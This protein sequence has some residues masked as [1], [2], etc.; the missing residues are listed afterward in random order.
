ME[1][2]FVSSTFRDMQ[3]ER[4]LLHTDIIPE[5]NARA[6]KYGEYFE[7]IDLRWG[8]NTS[9]METIDGAKKVMDVCFDEIDKSSPYMIIFLGNR[10]GWI[11]PIESVENA[12]KNRN[13]KIELI[14]KSITALEIEY[15]LA[16]KNFDRDKCIVC[17]RE[18]DILNEID[19]TN[20]KK[21][22]E[23]NNQDKKNLIKLKEMIISKFGKDIIFYNGSW[24]AAN[25]KISGLQELAA[26]IV[27][28]IESMFIS[29]WEK[30]KNICWQDKEKK[31]VNSFVEHRNQAFF[32]RDKLIENIYIN[33]NKDNKHI[34]AL[35]GQEGIGKTSCLCKI[36]QL[37]ENSGG[38]VFYFFSAKGYRSNTIIDCIK[39][40]IYFMEHIMMIDNHYIGD[41]INALIMKL[42]EYIEDYEKTGKQNIFI[43]IGGLDLLENSKMLQTLA[44]IPDKKLSLIKFILSF[45]ENHNISKVL[46]NSDYLYLETIHKLD[47]Y[48]IDC[49]LKGFLEKNK[50]ELDLKIINV[51]KSKLAKNSNFSPLYIQLIIQRLLM[52]DG[53]DLNNL[54]NSEM[55]NQKIIEI[56]KSCGENIEDLSFQIINIAIMRSNKKFI[57]EVISFLIVSRNGLKSYDL[58]KL[59]SKEDIEWNGLDFSKFLKYMDSFFILRQ[60]GEYDFIHRSVRISLLN[61]FDQRKKYEKKIF[62]WIKELPIKDD[63]RIREGVYFAYINRDF[64]FI[65]EQ[66]KISNKDSEIAILIANEIKKICYLDGVNWLVDII[67]NEV[68]IDT[69]VLIFDFILEYLIKILYNGNNDFD[70]K[71]RIL[72]KLEIKLE[73]FFKLY[74]YTEI[75]RC[76]NVVNSELGKCFLSH[77]NY[78]EAESYFKKAYEIC[79]YLFLNDSGLIDE[80]GYSVACSRLGD[81]YRKTKQFENALIYYKKDVEISEKLFISGIEENKNEYMFLLAVAYEK[82]GESY[83]GLDDNSNGIFYYNKA[84]NL[85]KILLKNEDNKGLMQMI[86]AIQNLGDAKIKVNKFEEAI[87]LFS[88]NIK[89]C[90]KNY[91]KTMELNDLQE[92]VVAYLKLTKGLILNNQYIKAD[93]NIKIAI[94]YLNDLYNGISSERTLILMSEGYKLEAV[95][96]IYKEEYNYA[97]EIYEK[98]NELLMELNSKYPKVQYLEM[99]AINWMQMGNVFKMQGNNFLAKGVYEIALERFELLSQLGINISSIEQKLKEEIKSL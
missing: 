97:V 88:V 61:K 32:G 57:K 36:G 87:E 35:K 14:E 99:T 68:K 26:Y 98:L 8:I 86:T 71:I 6:K 55:I 95:I 39:Q 91:N 62:E 54:V 45:E 96:A 22:L 64:K 89:N 30:E 52:I 75:L 66:M 77:Y 19:E 78:N 18:Q 56:I 37:I 24:D 9:D 28:R 70:I 76:L 33:I 93:K 80:I 60:N 4:D 13:C 58:E 82:I 47:D 34:F 63:F 29:K 53:D 49:I 73:I 38:E 50:K 2:I 17:F 40:I 7:F 65:I 41:D 12:F 81:V 27:N 83:V 67:E 15:Q 10:Y 3:A 90:E 51:I 1:R 92:L 85:Y 59:L 46:L 94:K 84:I 48:D 69:I 11:P 74:K 79:E 23:A 72:K 25:K 44:F 42:H 43:I 20:R 5:I 21:F 31:I 16:T